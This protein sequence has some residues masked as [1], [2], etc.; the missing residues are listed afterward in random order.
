MTSTPS[1]LR[2]LRGTSDELAR[3]F[4]ERGDEAIASMQSARTEHR[5]VD[6]LR[7]LYEALGAHGKAYGRMTAVT[8]D[9]LKAV[10]FYLARQ[11]GAADSKSSEPTR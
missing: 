8:N 6:Y 11:A 4:L 10:V 5:Y 9:M 2:Q 1:G 3:I 7:S